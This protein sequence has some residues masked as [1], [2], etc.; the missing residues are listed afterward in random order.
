MKRLGIFVCYDK[1]GIVDG[2][3][4]YLLSQMKA[5][6]DR[7]VIVSNVHLEEKEQKKLLNFTEFFLSG[8][9]KD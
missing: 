8:R 2:Y 1:E 5:V 7:L 6:L 4:T 9:T 3:V